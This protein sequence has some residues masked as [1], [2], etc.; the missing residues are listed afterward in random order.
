MGSESFCA[1]R[2]RNE[3]QVG[4]VKAPAMSPFRAERRGMEGVGDGRVML[5]FFGGCD[6]RVQRAMMSDISLSQGMVA[7]F[8][9][10]PSV[11]MR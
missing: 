6:W 1:A 4:R 8:E 5:F 2:A 3:G 7:T 10:D 9:R 11:P